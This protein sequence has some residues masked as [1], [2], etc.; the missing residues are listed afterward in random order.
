MNLVNNKEVRFLAEDG[1]RTRCQTD[2]SQK[3]LTETF[4]GL[5]MDFFLQIYITPLMG[6]R[7]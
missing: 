4:L 1:P 6:V 7:C 3:G 5:G 2:G